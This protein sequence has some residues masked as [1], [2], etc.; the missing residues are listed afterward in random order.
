[1]PYDEVIDIQFGIRYYATYKLDYTNDVPL[2]LQLK[3]YQR[4]CLCS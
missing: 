4:G 1:M 3:P 2:F